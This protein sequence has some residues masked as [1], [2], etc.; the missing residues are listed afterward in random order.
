MNEMGNEDY[1]EDDVLTEKIVT[2]Y[3]YFNE[4][5]LKKISRTCATLFIREYFE[6]ICSNN[7][8]MPSEAQM[9]D[10][11]LDE[12]ARNFDDKVVGAIELAYPDLDEE[13]LEEMLIRVEKMY[14]K[15]H[16]EQLRATSRACIKE[17]GIL[18]KS[19]KKD[20]QELKEKYIVQRVFDTSGP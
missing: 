8:V 14:Q 17:L 4:K 20:L 13:E 18:I 15:D 10:C 7:F 5:Y 3:G 19:L 2:Y 11:V 9:Q 16:Q 1:F 6:E 12:M